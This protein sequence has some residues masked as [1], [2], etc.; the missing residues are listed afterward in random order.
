MKGILKPAIALMNNLKYPQ[1]F[2]L[3][4][5]FFVVPITVAGYTVFSDMQNRANFTNKQL[6]G[7]SYLRLHRKLWQEIPQFQYSI[8]DKK[9]KILVKLLS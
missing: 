6:L 7:I 9:I 4:S 1:K 3:I 5:S 8:N 2:A